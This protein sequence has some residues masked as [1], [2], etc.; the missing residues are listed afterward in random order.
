MLVLRRSP[1]GPPTVQE[2]EV[3]GLG[4]RP[5]TPQRTLIGIRGP[6]LWSWSCRSQ[7]VLWRWASDFAFSSSA[8]I[9][10]TLPMLVRVD[11]MSV[12]TPLA[13]SGGSVK[14]RGFSR[15]GPPS[16]PHLHSGGWVKRKTKQQKKALLQVVPVAWKSR[17]AKA[18]DS[19]QSGFKSIFSN[20]KNNS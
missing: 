1:L 15:S 12:G 19:I 6:R 10:S 14:V 11:R 9:M 16:W 7:S 18:S 5:P 2:S 17:V 3:W 4:R 13:S 8:E 20:C